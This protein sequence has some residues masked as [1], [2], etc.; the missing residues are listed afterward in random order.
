[1]RD[2]IR[3]IIDEWKEYDVFCGPTV[4][5]EYKKGWARALKDVALGFDLGLV[6][7]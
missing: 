7:Y 1:M 6:E 5:E 3:T 4:W 2:E